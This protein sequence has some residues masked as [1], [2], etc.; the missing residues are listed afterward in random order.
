MTTRNQMA[1]Q[2][3]KAVNGAV[4]DEPPLGEDRGLTKNASQDAN[5]SKTGE[6][7]EQRLRELEE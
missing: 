7:E 2:N 4:E 3:K 5:S 6:N 1:R